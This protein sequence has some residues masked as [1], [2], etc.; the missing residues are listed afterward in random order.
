M[1]PNANSGILVTSTTQPK[2]E[3]GTL[4]IYTTFILTL[5]IHEYKSL[6]AVVALL[7]CL[8]PRPSHVVDVA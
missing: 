2:V 7:A 5:Q 3:N 6:K 4:V 8:V 1:Q